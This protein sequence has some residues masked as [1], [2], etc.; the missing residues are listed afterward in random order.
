MP[1]KPQGLSG[2]FY[3]SFFSLNFRSGGVLPLHLLPN[4]TFI[5]FSEESL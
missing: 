1:G 2:V 5:H 3:A 4:S